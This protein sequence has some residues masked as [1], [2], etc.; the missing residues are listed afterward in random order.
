MKDLKWSKV[1]SLCKIQ[2]PVFSRAY[3]KWIVF[4]SLFILIWPLLI[5]GGDILSSCDTI[6]RWMVMLPVLFVPMKMLVCFI[7][8]GDN[9]LMLPASYKEKYLSIWLTSFIVIGVEIL[10]SMVI[11]LPLLYGLNLYVFQVDFREVWDEMV[12]AVS[13]GK[14]LSFLAFSTGLVCL[15]ISSFI[16]ASKKRMVRIVL[17]CSFVL[18]FGTMILLPDSVKDS[19]IPLLSGA[20]S[21]CFWIWGYRSFKLI[22]LNQKE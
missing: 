4:L 22:Q 21:V 1:V 6:A 5:S 8:G 11:I 9:K 15:V 14:L 19:Y 16:I 12:N 7:G 17:V 10:L 13:L 18:I 20:F 2:A 3:G